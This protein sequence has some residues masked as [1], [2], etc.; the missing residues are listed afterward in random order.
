MPYPAAGRGRGSV[1]VS[2][3]GRQPV[4]RRVRLSAA[5]RMGCQQELLL[6][7]SA[8]LM[9]QQALSVAAPA[10]RGHGAV[11]EQMVHPKV[12][13]HLIQVRLLTVSVVRQTD[14]Y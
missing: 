2:T 14:R 6:P 1:T 8:L 10:L 3:A 13:Q 4:V 11:R 9:R 12:A 5:R 7:H